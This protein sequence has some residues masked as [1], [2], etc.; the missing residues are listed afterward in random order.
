MI[1][2]F[3]S[4]IN[5]HMHKQFF[6]SQTNLGVNWFNENMFEIEFVVKRASSV[7]TLQSNFEIFKLAPDS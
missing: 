1:L 7:I 4:I 3:I 5:K 6:R 2:Y